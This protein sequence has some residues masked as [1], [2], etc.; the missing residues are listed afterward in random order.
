MVN[1]V[2]DGCE[3]VGDFA[4][5]WASV[6]PH[7]FQGEVGVLLA[8]LWRRVVVNARGRRAL[9]VS[10]VAAGGPPIGD[11]KSRCVLCCDARLGGHKLQPM[12]E[13]IGCCGGTIGLAVDCERRVVVTAAAAGWN[14]LEAE[15]EW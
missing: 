12:A 11:G 13:Q 7:Q 4:E 8:R 3:G 6:L 10:P 1:V 15:W 14:L 2:V 5:L 9:L